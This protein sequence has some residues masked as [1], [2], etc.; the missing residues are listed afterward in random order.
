MPSAPTASLV[1]TSA[2][3]LGGLGLVVTAAQG[4]AG[5][6]QA[7]AE[8]FWVVLFVSWVLTLS[9]TWPE[10]SK[11]R[12]GF[13]ASRADAPS[14]LATLRAEAV[15]HRLGI[16]ATLACAILAAHRL[17]AQ[18]FPERLRADTPTVDPTEPIPVSSMGMLPLPSAWI[19]RYEAQP[20]R[21]TLLL[22]ELEPKKTSYTEVDDPDDE[23]GLRHFVLKRAVLGVRDEPSGIIDN[24]TVR[25]T[26]RRLMSD[27]ELKPGSPAWMAPCKEFHSDPAT[28]ASLTSFAKERGRTDLLR[29]LENYTVL[30]RAVSQR[31]AV[32]RQILPRGAE[33]QMLTGADRDRVLEWARKCPGLPNPVFRVGISNPT[34]SSITI[35]SIKYY[36][37]E[38]GGAA[39]PGTPPGVMEPVTADAHG[40]YLYGQSPGAPVLYWPVRRD[41]F[42]SKYFNVDSDLNDD[43]DRESTA[44]RPFRIPAPQVRSLKRPIELEPGKQAIFELQLYAITREGRPDTQG[45]RAPIL[46]RFDV[47]TTGGVVQVPEFW[48]DLVSRAG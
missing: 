30:D 20:Q 45:M 9:A 42:R 3:A 12:A 14:R 38:D 1:R 34:R 4:V 37:L 10:P 47:Q 17:H 21:P 48:V 27:D 5:F 39:G 29:H 28:L 22:F 18:W 31:A 44:Y 33:W 24:M 11:Q 6:S 16:A 41:L 23:I 35:K 32:V 40:L 2:A 36:L 26:R 13:A 8:N 7:L 15:R 43:W 46:M 25:T 19:A